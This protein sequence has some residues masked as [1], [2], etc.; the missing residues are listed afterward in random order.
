VLET[1]NVM[2]DEEEGSGL[3][4]KNPC[5]NVKQLKNDSLIINITE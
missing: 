5:A 3:I 4:S 2:L 1:F